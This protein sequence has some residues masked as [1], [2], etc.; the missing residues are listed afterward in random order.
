[1]L[2]GPRLIGSGNGCLSDARMTG[3]SL[4]LPLA[5]HPL[6]LSDLVGRHLGGYSI[7]TLDHNV[8]I[9]PPGVTSAARAL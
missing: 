2:S 3:D 1:M 7:A 4:R 8:A 9:D 5:R 6:R